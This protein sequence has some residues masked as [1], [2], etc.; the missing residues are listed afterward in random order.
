MADLSERSTQA[1]W[2]DSEEVPYEVFD[3]CLRDIARINRLTLAYRPTLNFLERV[4]RRYP[5][6]P[7][8]LL[9]AGSG[10]GDMVRVMAQ[11]A[12]KRRVTLHLTG[13][14]LNPFAAR[15]AHSATRV[16]DGITYQTCNIFDVPEDQPID[17]ITSS[18]FAHH[19]SHEELVA[20]IAWM[21]RRATL[22]W[23][24]NDLHRHRVAYHVIKHAAPFLSRNHLI[25]HDAPLSVARA[26]TR[27]DW[28]SLAP[29]AE[30][31]WWFPFRWTV[32]RLSSH[33]W[34]T[35]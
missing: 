26:F 27:S 5:D 16:E 4:R 11:W 19:L 15:S 25:R 22:G 30:L 31:R 3:Q 12:K 23:C 7:L 2:M 8:H 18:L 24:I 10:G 17:L 20:F 9:D 34:I 1:E 29:D 14:D 21:E 6:R 33:R 13:V 28:A 32:A 35:P